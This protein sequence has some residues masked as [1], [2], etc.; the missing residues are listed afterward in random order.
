MKISHI[1]RRLFKEKLNTTVIITS[2]TVGMACINLIILFISRELDT[3]SF[4]KNGDHIYLLKCDD[5]FNKGSKMFACRLG[6]AEYM[7]ENISQVEDFCRV[8]NVSV[9]KVI[10]SGQSF[11]DKL[12][13]YEASA[14]F[15]NFFTYDLLTRN[16][17][18]VLETKGD[19]AI[20]EEIAKKYFGSSLPVGQIFT[21]IS[22]NKKN[23]YLIKGIFKKP[24][25]NS[26]FT[27]DMVT[28]A[29]ESES[30][31]FILLKGNTDPADIERIFTAEKENIPSI[32]AGIPGRYY[33]ESI[34]Q[35]YFD[36]TQKGSLG[37]IRDLSDIWIAVIIGVM[38]LC[39]ALF[40]YLGLINNKLL[41]KSKEF[42][43]RQINGGSRA[44]II[45]EFILETFIV[46][47]I[48][49]TLSLIL[50]S[51]IA[52]F[53]NEFTQSNISSQNIFKANELVILTLSILFLLFVTLIFS[54]FKIRA[55]SITSNN[56]LLIDYK[57]KVIR[58]PLFNILQLSFTLIL[59]VCSFIIIKQIHYIS[60]KDIGLDMDVLEIKI[61]NQYKEQSTIFKAELLKKPVVTNI[62]LTP[63]SPLLEYMMAIYNYSE[64]GDEKQY[65]PALF[66]GD[67]NFINTLGIKI[68][69]G[70]NFSGNPSSDKNNCLVNESFSKK[71]IGKQLIGQKLPGN[72]N[73][74]IIGIVKNFHYSSLKNKIE[75]C[76]ITYDNSGNHLLVK[77]FPGQLQAVRKVIM[78]TWQKLIPDYPLN[79]ES[80]R[81]RYEWYHRENS[82]YAKF[83]GSCCFVS[84]FL[85][86]IGL[87]AISYN[88]CK[89]R[90]KEIGIHKINGATIFEMMYLLNNDF[91]RWLAI[92]FIISTPISWISMHNW[93][94]N[95]AYKT[96]L[97]WWI[98]AITGLFTLVITI[99][100]VSWLSWRAATMNPVEA[101]RYE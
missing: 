78:D 4:Q 79:I 50:L 10:T 18:S 92:A 83:I 24:I 51:A 72:E 6:A 56:K 66:S 98:F 100:T 58:I 12:V 20:S 84:L 90:T 23:D 76:I 29:K 75:P 88:S 28:F 95:F 81:E 54:F 59:S 57:G 25:H 34:K 1:F 49:F 74:I 30:F 46:I 38:I 17:N 44:S 5:P 99:L 9:Q 39:I 89:K 35:S 27:F 101:L 11:Y 60:S 82:N 69:D 48:A 61:P 13:L 55:L 68:E 8:K 85:S 7:K 42:Y 26:Q 19:I 71:F 94:E 80:V 14:N 96:N 62:S 33:L 70:R 65:T 91:L 31:A 43:I 63:A 53:F 97:D 32:N 2:L 45:G 15:F 36:T 87:F 3:D 41:D 64:N 16:P 21:L 93:L 67:E 52:P 40:N 86:M 73:L 77:S 37:T 22:G 47:I